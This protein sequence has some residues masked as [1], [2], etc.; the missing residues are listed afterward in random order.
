MKWEES[1]N[2]VGGGAVDKLFDDLSPWQHTSLPGKEDILS[3]L[4]YSTELKD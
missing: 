4:V 2:I 1:T 3:P